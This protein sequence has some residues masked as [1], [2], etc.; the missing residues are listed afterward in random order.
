M[1]EGSSI[2]PQLIATFG[3]T[4][5]AFGLG[6][7]VSWP[8][9]ALLQI[10]EEDNIQLSTAQES[11]VSSIAFIGAV[12]VQVVGAFAFPIIGKKWSLIGLVFP[13]IGGWVL[14]LTASNYAMLLIGRFLT[15]FSGGSFV[16]AA[17]AYVADIA[18][19][20]Y[21]G[22][23]GSTMQLMVN[24]GILFNNVNCNTNWRVS[25]GLCIIFPALLAIWMFF[26]PRSPV[27]LISKGRL[28]EAR[29]SLQFL[30][31]KNAK[32]EAELEL[33][34]NDV[35][36]TE[37]IGSIGPWKLITTKEYLKPVLI[38]MVLM[39]LQQVSGYL[40]IISYQ[41]LIF[42]SSGSSMDICLSTILV[43]GVQVVASV[44]QTFAV[45]KFGRKPLLIVSDLFVFISM[46]SV[47][48]FFKLYEN[49]PECR[50]TS[51]LPSL[52]L[53]QTGIEESSLNISEQTVSDIG[54][55]PLVGL[56]IFVFFFMIG[57]GPVGWLMNVELM[58][59]E[60]RAFGSSFCAC[61]NWSLSF[62]VVLL[63]PSINEALNPST[64]Y[65][66]FGGIAAAGTVFMALVLPET[67]GKTEQEIRNMLK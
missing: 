10:R 29:K 37:S 58:P 40:F 24:I 62:L 9:N 31:G 6:T 38:S 5:G 51:L 41:A 66:I 2:V 48:V 28:E 39:F 55:L 63:V 1:S 49:C 13:F 60:A 64:V 44:T 23:L 32:V 3:A 33:M 56:M 4:L 34:Q 45:E 35:K 65:F 15:G 20:K 50:K 8:S 18:E 43:G 7:V 14:L 17:P 46:V 26:M 57:L 47:G 53:T 19:P 67:K 36:E 25:T 22:A 61:F 42:E 11:L 52:H 30:R 12:L 21:R 16:L 54:W 59:M 27:F